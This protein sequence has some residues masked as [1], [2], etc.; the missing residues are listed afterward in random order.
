MKGKNRQLIGIAT[1]GLAMLLSGFLSGFFYGTGELPSWWQ[2]PTSYLPPEHQSGIDLN[3]VSAAIAEDKTNEQAYR[4]GWNCLDYAWA[5]MRA[6]SWQGIPCYITALQ[7]EDGTNHAVLAIPT[8]DEDLVWY[9]P[10]AD[11]KIEPEVGTIYQGKRVVGLQIMTIEWLTLD[12]FTE[13]MK[14]VD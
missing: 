8:N 12:E 4:P 7:Y 9:D 13:L 2:E 1:V 11:I 3:T 5:T 10:Q 6:L 14:E